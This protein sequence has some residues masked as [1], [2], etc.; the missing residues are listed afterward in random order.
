[1]DM[2]NRTL[3]GYFNRG[4]AGGLNVD[5]LKPEVRQKLDLFRQAFPNIPVISAFRDPTHNARVGG[6]SGSRHTHGDAID[7]LFKGIGE[8][9]QKQ[10]LDWWKGQGATG[11]GHY[12]GSAHVDFGPQRAWGPDRTRGSLGRTPQ[13]FQ[14]MVGGAPAAPVQAPQG[15]SAGTMTAGAAPAEQPQMA[16][17]SVPLNPMAIAQAGAPPV[18]LLA[19]QEDRRRQQAEQEAADARRKAA[20]FSPLAG[21]FG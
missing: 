21:M 2:Q 6:A 20:L 3:A 5:G 19:M 9:A 13:F 11:F 10:A 17:P 1:M 18:N 12:G 16:G 4:G 15:I 8:D 7:I 14:A